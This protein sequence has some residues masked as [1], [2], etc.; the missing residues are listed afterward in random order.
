MLQLEINVRTQVGVLALSDLPFH[1]LVGDYLTRV[2]L[3]D[4]VE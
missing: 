2:G 4:S 3:Q 1:D